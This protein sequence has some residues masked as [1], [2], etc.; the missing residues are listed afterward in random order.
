V[1]FGARVEDMIF[2]P[3]VTEVFHFWDGNLQGKI[4]SM[5][6]GEFFSQLQKTVKALSFEGLSGQSIW[7]QNM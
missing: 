5:S 6:E 1:L 4:T 3:R 7:G 2:P